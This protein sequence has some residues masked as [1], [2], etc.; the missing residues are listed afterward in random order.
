MLYEITAVITTYKREWKVVERAIKSVLVQ[1]YP[2]CEILVVDDNE[3]NSYY[4]E[5]IRCLCEQYD[6][7]RYIAQ[8]GNFGVAAARNRGIR[9][10]RGAYIAFLDDDDEWLPSKLSKQVKVLMMNANVGI[11][12]GY[13][14]EHDDRTEENKGYSWSSTVFEEQPT[15]RQMLQHDR[16]GSTSSPLIRVDVLM[17]V[18]QFREGKSL[19]VEDYELWIRIIREFRGYGLNEPLYIRHMDSGEHVSRNYNRT[20]AGYQYIYNEFLEDYKK[21][22]EAKTAILRNIVR[23]GIKAKNISVFPY[24]WRWLFSLLRRA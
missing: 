19:A 10:A 21:Y 22:P 2:V 14:V 15:Y 1:T 7:V 5:K 24:C 8:G 11:V 16:I 3:A 4:S 6:N 12:F 18:G 20:F 13:G 23:E 17:R 9:E